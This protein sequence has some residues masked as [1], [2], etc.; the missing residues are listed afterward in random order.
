M[1]MTMPAA[2]VPTI[3]DVR[4][5]ASRLAGVARRTPLLESDLLNQRL[6]GRLLVKAEALQRT[7]SFKFRGAYNAISRLNGR[8][9]VAFSSGNHAQGVALA[10]RLLGVPATIVM[11]AG[12]PA[13]KRDNTRALGADLRLYDQYRDNREDIGAEIAAATG[14]ALVK[15]YDDA[16][17]IAGQGTVGLELVAQAGEL[18]ASPDVILVCCGGGGLSAGCGLAFADLCPDAS[19][20]SVEP[21]GFDDTKRSLEAGERLPVTPGATSICDALLAPVPGAMTF[22]L[23]RRYLTG[24]LVVSDDEVRRAM[25]TAFEHFKLVVE[26]GG[27]VALAAAL[28]GRVETRGKTV[29]VVVSGGNVDPA[30]FLA[31]LDAEARPS[32]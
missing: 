15:P 32:V 25:A 12:A 17:V 28:H 1:V 16:R 26:P 10:A 21:Q 9:V 3:A 27:A 7:G 29:A 4:D 22:P 11:P 23:N 2:G 8:P 13:I 24:G 5:A 31:A 14:A 6:G 18:G 19:V 20:F 30:V